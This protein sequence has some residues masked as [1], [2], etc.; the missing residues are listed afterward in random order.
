MAINFTVSSDFRSKPKGYT[1]VVHHSEH[2]PELNHK[3]KN[4]DEIRS[5]FN[6]YENTTA[7]LEALQ[8]WQ[9]EKFADF[10]E[11]H[12]AHQREKGHPERQWGTV[13]KYLARKNKPTAVITLGSI[14]SQGELLQELCPADV[15]TT[16]HSV[17]GYDYV[18]FDIKS[19]DELKT[20][21]DYKHQEKVKSEAKK[22]FGCYNR[23]LFRATENNLCWNTGNNDKPV[24]LSDYIFMG[25]RATNF[26][27]GA[28]HIHVELGAYGITRT[29]GKTTCSLNQALVAVHHAVTGKWISGSKSL[30]WL[31]DNFDRTAL[32]YLNQELQ[33]AYNLKEPPVEF[34]RKTEKNPTLLTGLPMNQFK[35]LKHAEDDANKAKKAA[36]EATKNANKAIEQSNLVSKAAE[37]VGKQALEAQKQITDATKSLKDTYEVVTGSQPVDKD[38]KELSPL[39]M[40]KG[41]KSASSTLKK[42]YKETSDKL[43]KKYEDLDV[44]DRQLG[45]QRSLILAEKQ[46]LTE[47]IEADKRERKRKQKQQEAEMNEELAAYQETID[48]QK[49]QLDSQINEKKGVLQKLDEAI[50]HKEESLKQVASRVADYVMKNIAVTPLFKSFIDGVKASIKKQLEEGKEKPDLPKMDKQTL[51]DAVRGVKSEDL[52]RSQVQNP[53]YPPLTTDADE[54]ANEVLRETSPL[55]FAYDKAKTD[56]YSLDKYTHNQGQKDTKPKNTNGKTPDDGPSL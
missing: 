47:Q 52:V 55:S 3:N 25:R 50:K 39:E 16:K 46:R 6:E 27:E 38:G 54:L 49:H 28:G 5:E 31:R 41:V 30:S 43:S 4:I 22:F 33:T 53:K 14:Q 36:E 1:G 44:A 56:K 42:E 7:R 13:K 15:L 20:E 11:T 12:D 37:K 45:T 8:K 2:D 40:A 24:L 9:Q 35:T 48:T 21:D 10:I 19:E 34:E 32:F 18:T 17:E 26:D 23:A 51:R 29:G